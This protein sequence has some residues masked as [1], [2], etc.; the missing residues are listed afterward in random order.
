M[1]GEQLVGVCINDVVSVSA[2]AFSTSFSSKREQFGY[3]KWRICAYQLRALL[4]SLNVFKHPLNSH[5]VR[6]G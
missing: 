4:W 1:E 5:G 3:Q 2:N 6:Q